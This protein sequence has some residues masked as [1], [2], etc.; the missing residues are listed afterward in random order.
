MSE[1]DHNISPQAI[2]LFDLCKTHGVMVTTAES[3][4]GG[5]IAAAITDIAGSSAVFDR[6]FVTYS[7]E[8]KMAMIGVKSST[9]DQFGA[10]SQQTALEM[11]AGALKHSKASLSIAVTGVAGPSGGTP[12]KPVG[13]VHIAVNLDGEI[14]HEE[15]HF[16][17]RTRS[18]IRSETVRRA[19][20][21]SA[22]AVR[23]RYAVHA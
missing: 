17:A 20:E 3:C 7:N 19:L 1:V 6:G 13:L 4:T 11:A 8:A 16:G 18:E 10:V 5:M 23:K 14:I 15:C 9:I 22:E 2:E 21:L 12:K